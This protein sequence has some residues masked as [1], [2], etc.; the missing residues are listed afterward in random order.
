VPS[1]LLR[2][3]LL[4]LAVLLLGT[5]PAAAGEVTAFVGFPSPTETWGQSYG[6]TLTSTWFQVVAL[7]AEAA[8][9]RGDDV[10]DQMTSFT[11][12]ALLAPPIGAITPYAGLGVGVFRQT[13]GTP[14]DNGT[15]RAYIIG[16]K[17]KLGLVVV[18]GDYRQLDLGESPLLP[19]DRRISLGAGLTF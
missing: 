14:A 17:L 6:A 13:S 19:M 2:R 8:R 3:N 4:G 1:N 5:T 9:V 10:S 18:R 16:A 11:A 12:A 7:E 15:L